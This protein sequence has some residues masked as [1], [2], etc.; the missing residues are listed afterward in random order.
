MNTSNPVNKGT[1]NFFPAKNWLG[2]D[3]KEN[4]VSIEGND[5][6]I[7]KAEGYRQGSAKFP[8]ASISQIVHLR[9]FKFIFLVVFYTYELLHS[10]AFVSKDGQLLASIAFATMRK[11]QL[12]ALLQAIIKKNPNVSLDPAVNELVSTGSTKMLTSNFLKAVL[13]GT[14][15]WLAILVVLVII[16]VIA[17]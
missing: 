13:K 5:I 6:V 17:S 3:H 15:F 4:G 9:K 7:N 11:E 2:K 8:I 10:I 14:W 16:G 1:S 12:R